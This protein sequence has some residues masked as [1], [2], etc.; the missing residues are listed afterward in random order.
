ML[1]ASHARPVEGENTRPHPD[2]ERRS[3]DRQ[4]IDVMAAILSNGNIR[5]FDC[6]VCDISISGARIQADR[7]GTLPRRF[8]LH[9][10]D[11]GLL[12]PCEIVWCRA[13]YAG[14]RFA[15]QIELPE[16]D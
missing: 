14:I 15:E 4:P 7:V 9:I 13:G 2:G 5:M 16:A 12:M 8:K 3:D 1:Q 10:E 6:K 11:A